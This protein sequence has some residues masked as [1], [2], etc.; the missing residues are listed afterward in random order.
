MQI[1]INPNIDL[2]RFILHEQEYNDVQQCLA[3]GWE[4]K[5]YDF[6]FSFF[7]FFTIAQNS[8]AK[9]FRPKALGCC[10]NVAVKFA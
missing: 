10:K 1:L 4:N 9:G 7:G 2:R 8:R 5:K 3:T 6:S